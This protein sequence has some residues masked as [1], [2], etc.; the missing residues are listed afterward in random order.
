MY[1][2]IHMAGSFSKIVQ[3]AGLV[4][5]FTSSISNIALFSLHLAI[6]REKFQVLKNNPRLY[7]HQYVYIDR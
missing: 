6:L 4:T 3:F 2:C 5:V 7:V 1:L